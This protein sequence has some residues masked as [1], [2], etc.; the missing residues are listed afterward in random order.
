MPEWHLSGL[1]QAAHTPQE[2]PRIGLVGIEFQSAQK[3]SGGGDIVSFLK[4]NHTQPIVNFR[5]VRLFLQG[6]L[7]ISPGKMRFLHFEVT[8]AEVISNVETLLWIGDAF[9]FRRR[10]AVLSLEK[11]DVRDS[12]AGSGTIPGCLSQRSQTTD[13][14][15]ILSSG[16]QQVSQ[17]ELNARTP[18][19]AAAIDLAAFKPSCVRPI[20]KYASQR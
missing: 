20:R 9:Q 8:A 17:R 3:E 5:G 14:L 12:Q 2:H 19:P 16:N 13:R 1:S 10:V 18:P 6:Q 11:K 7:K 15:I 4:L